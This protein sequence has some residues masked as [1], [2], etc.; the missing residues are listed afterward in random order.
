MLDLA[1]MCHVVSP[2][3]SA[4]TKIKKGWRQRKKGTRGRL[5]AR[6]KE[7]CRQRQKYPHS[8]PSKK[9]SVRPKAMVKPWYKVADTLSECSS[10]LGEYLSNFM[11]GNR[12]IGF[13]ARSLLE[14]CRKDANKK[15]QIKPSKKNL[16]DHSYFLGIVNMPGSKDMRKNMQKNMQREETEAHGPLQFSFLTYQTIELLCGTVTHYASRFLPL[17]RPILLTLSVP[18]GHKKR[19]GNSI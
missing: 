2:N 7:G 4:E 13:C 6:Q 14:D 3:W 8:R 17:Y 19:T 10:C 1:I 15:A 9:L 12:V 16:F 11:R 5:W 18:S